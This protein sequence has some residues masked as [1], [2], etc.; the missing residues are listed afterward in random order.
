MKKNLCFLVILII[1][2]G[3]TCCNVSI[4]RNDVKMALEKINEELP[5]RFSAVTFV[6]MKQNKNF[7]ELKLIHHQYKDVCTHPDFLKRWGLYYFLPQVFFDNE[8]GGWESLVKNNGYGF[9]LVFC[10]PTDDSRVIIEITDNEILNALSQIS[11][12]HEWNRLLLH[13]EADNTSILQNPVQGD[14]R[15]L[16]V[17]FNDTT[18]IYIYGLYNYDEQMANPKFRNDQAI[19]IR[20]YLSSAYQSTTDESMI[21]LMG[22]LCEN[23]ILLQYKYYS[24][25]GDSIVIKFTPQE[26]CGYLADKE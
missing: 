13:L 1:M 24:P 25:I 3:L 19:K 5:T 6:S 12:N 2:F 18:F 15:C 7:F 10:S 22:R 4:V 23:E 8:N 20:S 16:Q 14:T 26:I 17:L 21:G 9:R 11:D